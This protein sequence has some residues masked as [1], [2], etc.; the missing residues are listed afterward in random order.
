MPT[1]HLLGTGAAFSDP[2]R[3]T[4]MLAFTDADSTI[5]VDCGGDVVQR[6]MQAG[7]ALNTIDALIVTHEHPDHVGGFPLFIERL[8]LSGRK[9]P[10]HVYGIRS[11][12][13]Q[14][15]RC[16][17]IFDT[18]RWPGVPDRIWHEVAH[19]EHAPV[20]DT[21]LWRIT[22]SPGKHGVPVVGLRVESKTSEKTAVYSCDTRPCD[23]ILRLANQADLF[24]HEATGAGPVHSSIEEAAQIAAK[25]QADQLVLVHLPPGMTDANLEAAHPWHQKVEFGEEL[26][27]YTF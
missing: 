26:T 13:D 27:T 23:T 11:A 3:T 10:F 8:W 1:L 2:H 16:F 22:A 17:E 21:N 12:I 5:V 15:R 4:T 14:A 18:D 20:L 6:L 24:I 9:K 7:I 19:E 25:A